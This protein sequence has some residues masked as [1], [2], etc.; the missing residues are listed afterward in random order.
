MKKI[1][2]LLL[3]FLCSFSVPVYAEDFQIQLTDNHLTVNARDVP[4]RSILLHLV[5]E[6]ITVKFDP[7]IKQTVTAHF[8][9]RPI[10]QALAAIVKP[11]S[12]SL[13]WNKTLDFSG[14]EQFA[15]TEIRIF[16]TGR[17]GS[18]RPLLASGS[19]KIVQ[20]KDGSLYIADK[21]LLHLPQGTNIQELEKELQK[22][23]AALVMHQTLAGLATVIFPENSD[24]FAIAQEIKNKLDLDMVEPNY[25][26]RRESPLRY[27]NILP[28]P[29]VKNVEDTIPA[30]V[31]P[32]AILDSGINE[33]AGLTNVVLTSHN[34]MDTDTRIDDTLGHGTQM[35]FIASGLIEPYGISNKEGQI[36]PVIPIKTFDDDGHATSLS[37]LE[38][39][40]FSLK[41]D[42]KVMSL[43]WGTEVNSEFME[44]AFARADEEGLIIVAAAGNEP[45]GNP[46]YP[47]A[48]SFIIGVGALQPDGKIWSESNHG[49][50]VSLYAPGFANMPVG[51][52]G[53]PGLYGGTSIS[54][55]LVANNIATYINEHPNA[56]RTEIDMF[57]KIEYGQ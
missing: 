5:G 37:I 2:L 47:A 32:V 50:F 55:A 40:D 38:S 44:D 51:Y 15:L 33:D 12:S 27:S 11:A 39:I 36:I 18:A 49:D 24:V 41:N 30:N 26:Y 25:V 52:N 28:T 45:T 21:L 53:E 10:E 57:L 31:P 22:Y 42:A 19:G 43:S 46:V 4:L 7:Q 34:A 3:I 35:A 6:G 9:K 48:Y 23:G 13:I 29:E 17:E 16:Q 54:A 1:N 14:H 8:T 20:N 56:T